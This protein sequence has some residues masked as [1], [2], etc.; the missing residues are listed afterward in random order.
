MSAIGFTI[1][2]A[3]A[4]PAAVGE[5]IYTMGCPTMA[6]VERIEK[7]AHGS[8]FLDWFAVY[9]SEDYARDPMVN[10]TVFPAIYTWHKT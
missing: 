3:F 5:Q 4:T 8:R 1:L 6:C 10:T 7:L 9:R 2:V